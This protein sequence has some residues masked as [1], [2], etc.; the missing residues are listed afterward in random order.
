MSTSPTEPPEERPVQTEDVP[1]EEGVEEADAARQ[2]EE[3][4]EE[5]ANYTDPEADKS[6][7]PAGEHD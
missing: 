5:L 4:P 2:V 7:G 3:D 6:A 1:V